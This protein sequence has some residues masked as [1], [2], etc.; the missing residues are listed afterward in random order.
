MIRLFDWALDNGGLW[1]LI[2]VVLGLV[3]VY[4]YRSRERDLKF[5][6]REGRREQRRNLKLMT[7]L[8]LSVREQTGRPSIT[9][10]PYDAEPAEPSV[11]DEHFVDWDEPTVV[12]RRKQQ[13][14]STN[15][16]QMVH[17]Y[18]QST[19]KRDGGDR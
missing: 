17:D 2:A 1:A 7:E 15:I 11:E 14:A 12:T 16:K 10:R 4:L 8:A 19:R 5:L 9:S 3:V 13:S 6:H 18:M